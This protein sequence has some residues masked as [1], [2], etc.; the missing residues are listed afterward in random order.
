[1]IHMFD[2]MILTNNEDI[3]S[4]PE[5]S[6]EIKPLSTEFGL[7]VHVGDPFNNSYTTTDETKILI[8]EEWGNNNSYIVVPSGYDYNKDRLNWTSLYLRRM[9][10]T[11]ITLKGN[12]GV[13]R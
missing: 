11:N 9:S 10:A 12:V 2:N 4:L 5:E 8:L 7:K 1:M 13:W 3:S 6:V